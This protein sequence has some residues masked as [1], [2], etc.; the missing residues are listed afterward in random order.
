MILEYLKRRQEENFYGFKN[1]I[2]FSL[3]KDPEGDRGTPS[4]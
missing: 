2:L 1:V 4:T 3:R